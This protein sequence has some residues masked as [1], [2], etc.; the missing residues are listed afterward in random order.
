LDIPG[1]MRALR[2]LV[3]YLRQYRAIYAWGLLLVVLSNLFSTLGP[4]F[5]QRGID[6][7]A[8]GDPFSNVQSA[9]LLLLGVAAVGGVARYGMRELLNSSSRRVEYDLRNRLYA[10]LEGQSAEFY[11]RYPTGDVMAR[12]T[13]DLLAVRMV[14]GPALMYLADTVIR[15]LI[16]VPVM[17]HISPL[18]SLLALVPL[19][20]LPVVMSRFGR[21]IHR[22]SETIQAQFSDLTTHAHENLSGVRIV[23]AYRQ[24]A[25]EARHFR[26]LNEEYT[27]RNLSLA[28]IQGMFHPLLAMLGGLGMVA[29]LYAGG[30]LVITGAVS[31]GEYIAF[32]VYLA[33]LIWPMIALGWVVNL[34]QRGAASMGRINALMEE[35]L[36]ITSPAAP[37][38]LPL[39]AGGRRVAF[40][41]V[42]FRYPAAPD[43]G[44][45]LQDITFELPAGG[46]LA[47][48]GA[49]GAGKS[50]LGELLV[51][52]YDAERGR[53]TLD[54]VDVREIALEELRRNIG[55]VP[56]ETFLFSD[57]I[58]NNILL[59]APDDGRLERAAEVAQLSEALP[60][61]PNGY[62]TM[63]GERGVNLSGGQKQR[64]AI[65]R[66]LAQNPPVFVLDDAL[67]AV[68]AQTEARI[69]RGLRGAL[70]RRTSIV[71]SHRLAA[72][73]EADLILVLDDGRIVERGTHGELMQLGGRYWEL[74]RRQELETELEEAV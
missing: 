30:R 38:A 56:Q 22:R 33:M 49:T 51:R 28:R 21:A 4:H 55:F 24:E 23:R 17:V 59:G 25:A 7:L 5:L 32:G 45:I 27:E 6:A 63:L 40:E 19:A 1:T 11:D 44:W 50:T 53:I 73:R 9:A 16:V 15:S 47:I 46:S 34:V 52:I 70:E 37:V 39:A 8:H 10:Y 42:W 71:I 31:V 57:T 36:A 67:S 65:A 58:R 29:L 60:L 2:A 26:A 64:A 74:L 13:N 68:D 72:V 3:P 61:L 35:P 66:A 62:D 41:G 54:G 48:V 14:A 18:L 12:T 20:A 43:R 69:L